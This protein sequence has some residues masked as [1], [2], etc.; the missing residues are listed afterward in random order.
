MCRLRG[1]FKPGWA[2]I[3]SGPEE[4]AYG[5]VA[6]NYLLGSLAGGGS[7]GAVAG[8]AGPGLI[9]TTLDLG[10]SSLEVRPVLPR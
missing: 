8:V 3:I 4:G 9:T 10:G 5:W 1:R 7:G 2:R 6:A